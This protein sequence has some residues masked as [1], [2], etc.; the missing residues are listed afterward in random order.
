MA[1]SSRRRGAKMP[2]VSMKTSWLV[3][4]MAMPRTGMRVVCTLWLTIDTLAP[5][6][7]LTSVDLPALGAPMTA[8]KPQRVSGA[9]R[10]PGHSSALAPHAL[11]REQR[12]G[13]GLLGGALAGT[14]A[15]R[16]LLALDAHL[17]GEARR[18]VGALARDLL[19]LRQIEALALRP[20]LQGRLG[21]GGLGRASPR[22]WRPSA[23]ARSRAPC[24]SR[25]PGRWR[26]AAPR[27]RPPGSSPCRGRRCS[28]PTR[29]AP[30]RRRDR[31]RA[32]PR[33]RCR[34]ARGDCR[35]GRA[36]PRW[37]RDRARSGARRW[38]GPA[39]GRPGTRGARCRGA[40]RRPGARWHASAPS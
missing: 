30:A 40:W 6:S 14:L 35:G 24:R 37:R 7:A 8:M 21:V 5:T 4:S 39:R 31:A 28:P 1:R 36:G 9:A 26:R 38:R 16:G 17:G 11:A 15:A 22:A 19:V 25:P 20:L 13:G 2:G 33:R 29:S 27:R 23:C 32:P 3:P 18:V 34:R 10:A 12:R